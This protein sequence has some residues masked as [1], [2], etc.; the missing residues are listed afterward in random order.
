M[1]QRILISPTRV[2]VSRP[3]YDVVS[4]PAI[5]TDYLS[6]DSSFGMPLRLLMSGVIYGSAVNGFPTISYPTTYGDFPMVHV[7]PFTSGSITN[8]FQKWISGTQEY[9]HQPYNIIFRKNNFTL[10]RADGMNGRFD[11]AYYDTVRNW[12][13]FVFPIS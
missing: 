8:L 3:G 6:V 5:S 12:I 7:A 10:G 4:P 13:Y 1:T 9:Y 2:A 11:N